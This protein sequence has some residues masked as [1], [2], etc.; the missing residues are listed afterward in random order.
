MSLSVYFSDYAQKVTGER[1]KRNAILSPYL[2][3]WIGVG[4]V[5][6]DLVL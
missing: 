5:P 6:L 2:S 1:Q 3:G 4:S